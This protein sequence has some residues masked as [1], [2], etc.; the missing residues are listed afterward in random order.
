MPYTHHALGMD[1]GNSSVTTDSPPS[2]DFHPFESLS[3]TTKVVIF[4]I[5]LILATSIAIAAIAY[6]ISACRKCCR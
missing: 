3:L 5:G 1:D 6:L 2:N 4:V